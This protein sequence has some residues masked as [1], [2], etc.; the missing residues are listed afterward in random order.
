MNARQIGLFTGPLIFAFTAFSA[1]PAGMDQGAWMVAGLVVW[2]A[3]WWI[4]EAVPMTVTG[5]LPFIWLP[6]G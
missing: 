5:L 3:A 4:T 1:P 2:M 6:P